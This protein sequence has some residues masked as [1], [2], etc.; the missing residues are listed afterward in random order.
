MCV[1][2]VVNDFYGIAWHY[3]VCAPHKKKVVYSGMQ[4]HCKLCLQHFFNFVK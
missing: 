4:T 1:L 2:N 3:G